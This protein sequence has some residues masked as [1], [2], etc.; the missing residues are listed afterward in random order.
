[1]SGRGSAESRQVEVAEIRRGLKVLARELETRSWPC[2]SCLA[3][4]ELRADKRP[5]LADLRESGC[6]VADTRVLRCRHRR[7]GPLGE[8]LSSGERDVPVWSLGD[9]W[10]MVPATM[11]HAFP[12]R[13]PSRRSAL[14][15]PRAG[16]SPP[17][18]TTRS[19]RLS[20]WRRLDELA[21]GSRI[22]TPRRIG[23][24]EQLGVPEGF[25]PSA[26]AR[27]SV[28]AGRL[29]PA[30]FSLPDEQLSAV[31]AQ[32]FGLIGSYGCRGAA[33]SPARAP[34][35]PPRPNAA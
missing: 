5:M 32:V 3:R 22:A 23:A 13:H 11:S 35:P 24:P 14:V 17:R 7:R 31:L 12:Q 16:R 6:L 1:M 27:S 29:D 25:E 15:S 20:G 21:V 19:A 2:R 4:L 34:S 8:L 28:A 18:P 9:D 33:G 30:A 26:L 10:Q